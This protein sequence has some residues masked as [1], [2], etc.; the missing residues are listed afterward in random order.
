LSSIPKESAGVGS[1]IYDTMREIGIALGVAVIGSV[2]ASLYR[3]R[4]DHA[5]ER[6][7]IVLPPHALH[8]ARSSLG[9]ALDV[10]TRA[11]AAGGPLADAARRA[12]T[13]GFHVGFLLTA[14]MMVASTVVAVVFLPARART[15]PAG[16]IAAMQIDDFALDAEPA[17]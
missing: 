10:A 17:A 2:A 11:G 8:V 13:D 16:A 14:G 7:G 4:L 5:L 1:A 6:G 3:S 9:G 15:V 12:F